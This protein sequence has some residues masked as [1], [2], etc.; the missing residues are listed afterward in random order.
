M[1]NCNL[2][3]L[4]NSVCPIFNITNLEKYSPRAKAKMIKLDHKSDLFKYCT[5]CG[6]CNLKCPQNVDLL[7]NIRRMRGKI[8][9]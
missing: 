7:F 9:K 8:K 2:C 5:E 1:K 4:C 6:A 3:G